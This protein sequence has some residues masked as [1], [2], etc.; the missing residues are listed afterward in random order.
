MND[1]LNL[2]HLFSDEKM[3][4]EQSISS[5][6]YSLENILKFIEIR[7][8]FHPDFFLFQLEYGIITYYEKIK[9]NP[10]LRPYAEEIRKGLHTKISEEGVCSI[11]NLLN[12]IKGN[13]FS[14]NNPNNLIVKKIFHA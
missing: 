1:L 6:Q 7:D 5:E 8:S 11:V 4:A 2:A 9:C 10:K 13:E 14:V 12:K 3:L